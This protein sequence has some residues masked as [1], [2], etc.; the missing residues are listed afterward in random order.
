MAG[1]GAGLQR[2]GG[3]DNSGYLLINSGLDKSSEMYK[4]RSIL[5]MRDFRIAE[6]FARDAKTSGILNFSGMFG[7]NPVIRC[8]CSGVSSC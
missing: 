1:G 2:L 6:R 5:I 7:Y 4:S 3:V 8:Y